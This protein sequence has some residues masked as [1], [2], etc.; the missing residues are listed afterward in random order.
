METVEEAGT[1]TAFS[2]SSLLSFWT[3]RMEFMVVVCRGSQVE[4]RKKVGGMSR[5]VP[6]GAPAEP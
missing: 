6:L 5:S 3:S 2:S 1:Y 4:K